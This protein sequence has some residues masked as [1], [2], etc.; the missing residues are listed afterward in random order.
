M[1][2]PLI[3]KE[4]RNKGYEFVTVTDL[5]QQGAQGTEVRDHASV[6]KSIEDAG[7]L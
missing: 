4:L 7:G 3:I 5:L 6:Q 1:K 2:L